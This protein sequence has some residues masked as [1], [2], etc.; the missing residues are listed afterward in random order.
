MQR[1]V[2]ERKIPVYVVVC[3]GKRPVPGSVVLDPFA[4]SGTTGCAAILD[5]RDFQGIEMNA[6]YADIANHRCRHWELEAENTPKSL[7]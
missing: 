2:R 4:G 7:F 3:V 6:E 1:A 5:G